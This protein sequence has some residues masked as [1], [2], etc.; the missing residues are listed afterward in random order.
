MRN[1][2]A[3]ILILILVPISF[4]F[5]CM[6]S[7]VSAS[8]TGKIIGQLTDAG[9]GQPIVGASVIIVGTRR[10]AMT[11]FDGQYVIS[12]LR[13]GIY[14]LKISHLDYETV[15]IEGVEVKT[16]TSEECS[17]EPTRRVKGE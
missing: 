11:D 10:G 4:L 14:T 12:E 8:E 15:T 2:R 9:T 3:S 5:I 1:G 6:M 13:P 7:S 17:D 16:D